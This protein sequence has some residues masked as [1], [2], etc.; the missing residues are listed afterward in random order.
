[1][2]AVEILFGTPA[3]ATLIREKKTYQIESL[4]QTGRRE[5]MQ[6]FED[7]LLGM[8]RAGT[9]LAEEAS[10]LGLDPD[11]LD[12]AERDAR[13]GVTESDEANDFVPLVP[14]LPDEL[15]DGELPRPGSLA[16][17]MGPGR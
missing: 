5:G 9:V 15:E 7:S 8:V 6:T 12:R 13:E 4:M 11:L 17:R 3:V 14:S 10:G 1:M 2:A 16:A